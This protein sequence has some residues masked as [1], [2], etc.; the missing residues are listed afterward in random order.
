[1]RKAVLAAFIM[2]AV[3]GMVFAGGKAD[4]GFTISTLNNPFFV[5][6]KDGAEAKAKALGVNLAVTDAGNDPAKQVKDIEDLVNKGIK[7]LIV[8]PV[9]SAA[10]APAIKEVMNKGVKI[11]AVDRSVDGV[12]VDTYIGTN[13]LLAANKAGKYFVQLVKPGAVIAVLEGVPSTSSNIDR[14]GGYKQ[15][16]DEAG[17]TIAI[18]QTANYNRAEA[19]TVTENILQSNPNITAIIAMNDEMALG[20]IEAV[21]AKGKTPGKDILITGFDAG[22][23]AVAAVKAGEMIYTVEQKPVLMG[24]TAVDTA[25]KYIDG[26]SV[27][28]VIPVDVEIVVK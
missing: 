25:K 16:L 14:V 9:D 1:M 10:V 3:C 2:F 26:A 11:I 7:V 8:N 4:V 15:A 17:L 20:A 27:Q 22:D 24:E 12:T 18:M 19:L 23:D 5:S 13:N 21:R 28:A 6:M